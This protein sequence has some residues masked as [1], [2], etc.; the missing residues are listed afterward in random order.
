MCI[1]GVIHMHPP[2]VKA[3]SHCIGPSCNVRVTAYSN[4]SDNKS[5]LNSNLN[6]GLNSNKTETE[7]IKKNNNDE[8]KPLLLLIGVE[9]RDL[10][11]CDRKR[12]EDYETVVRPAMPPKSVKNLSDELKAESIIVRHSVGIFEYTKEGTPIKEIVPVD[13]RENANAEEIEKYRGAFSPP[14]PSRDS[15][16]NCYLAADPLLRPLPGGNIPQQM[17]PGTAHYSYLTGEGPNFRPTG[18]SRGRSVLKEFASTSQNNFYPFWFESDLRTNTDLNSLFYNVDDDGNFVMPSM[19]FSSNALTSLAGITKQWF[20]AGLGMFGMLGDAYLD[21]KEI[22]RKE[23]EA[24]KYTQ[25]VNY[26]EQPSMAQTY[27][28]VSAY[29]PIYG[30]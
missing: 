22:K 5:N 27:Y 3:Q 20:S 10:N 7:E 1:L 23:R 8:K 6:S 29:Q 18:V 15:K 26:Y 14:P 4:F 16:A 17:Y 19:K 24:K 12:F 21:N 11:F 13:P 25:G 30:Y 28:P 9:L 2:K